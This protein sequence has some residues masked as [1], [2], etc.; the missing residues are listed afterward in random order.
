MQGSEVWIWMLFNLTYLEAGFEGL[1]FLA[2]VLEAKTH[3]AFFFITINKSAG[4]IH[5]K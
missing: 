5:L 4:V 2:F 1:Y 3:A